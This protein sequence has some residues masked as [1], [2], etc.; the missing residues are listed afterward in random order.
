MNPELKKRLQKTE[1]SLN[2]AVLLCRIFAA[3]LL[4]SAL[5][6][7]ALGTMEGRRLL[8]FFLFRSLPLALIVFAASVLLRRLFLEPF[9]R[10]AGWV[11]RTPARAMSMRWIGQSVQSGYL[12]E[13]YDAAGDLGLRAALLV[14]GK[15]GLLWNWTK[16]ALVFTPAGAPGEP[17]LAATDERIFFG[18]TLGEGR[19]R[20]PWTTR[21]A[22]AAALLALFALLLL[23]ETWYKRLLSG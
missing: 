16:E 5:V 2:L 17:I 4:S 11:E 21:L 7:L 9:L 6:P 22:G 20:T 8:L 1:R 13:F 10:A 18:R 12:A 19:G 3:L 14:D 15:P 23:M